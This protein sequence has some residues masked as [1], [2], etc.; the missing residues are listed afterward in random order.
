MGARSAPKIKA[1]RA[2]NKSHPTGRAKR[3]ENKS[4]STRRA[5]RAENK[6]HPTGGPPKKIRAGPYNQKTPVS[7][8]APTQQQ[9]DQPLALAFDDSSRESAAF[10]GLAIVKD[11]LEAFNLRVAAATN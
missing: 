3:A 1:K 8:P 11:F 4:H 9:D 7:A 10:F 5:K 6:S 2:E